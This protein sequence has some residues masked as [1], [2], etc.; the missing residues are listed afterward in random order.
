MNGDILWANYASCMFNSLIYFIFILFILFFAPP[1]HYVS[2]LHVMYS[3]MFLTHNYCVII[4]WY[5]YGSHNKLSVTQNFTVGVN[6]KYIYLVT[7]ES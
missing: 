7:T 6:R 3:L 2:S 5:L 4:M 1:L